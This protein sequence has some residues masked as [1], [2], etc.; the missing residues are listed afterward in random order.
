MEQ[1]VEFILEYGV[2]IGSVVISA[3]FLLVFALITFTSNRR[4]HE[5]ESESHTSITTPRIFALNVQNDH[6]IFFNRGSYNKRREGTMELFYRQF[7]V[8]EVSRIQK[9]INEL[10]TNDN[11]EQHFNVDVFVRTMRRTVSSLLLVKSIE[12]DKQTIHLESF[13]FHHLSPRHQ[14]NQRYAKKQRVGEAGQAR[15]EAIFNKQGTR[16]FGFFGAVSLAFAKS[17]K[18]YEFDA[19]PHIL[20]VLKDI[21]AMYKNKFQYVS[22]HGKNQ[23]AIYF[24]KEVN[25]FEVHK[26]MLAI[27][28]KIESFFE[29]NGITMYSVAHAVSEA[30]EFN[31]FKTFART[32]FELSDIAHRRVEKMIFY[33]P[34]DKAPDF[35]LTYFKNEISAIINEKAF[36][37]NFQPLVD[38]HTSEVFGQ[39]ASYT[40]KHPLFKT[41]KELKEYAVATK[42]EEELFNVTLVETLAIFYNNR[43]NERQHIFIP[44][45]LSENFN[46]QTCF[47]T[48][49]NSPK[50]N[51]VFMIEEED[52]AKLHRNSDE[53][54]AARLKAISKKVPLALIIHDTELTLPNELYAHFNYFIVDHKILDKT[55]KDER[56]RLYLLASLGKLTRYNR[57]VIFHEL[58]K[59]SEIEYY[60][61][62]G[63]DYVSSNEISKPEPRIVPLDKR[64]AMR[65]INF[66]KRKG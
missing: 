38:P 21:A 48:L 25:A 43:R 14:I 5:L 55:S 13:L 7:S 61:R 65:I 44:L 42:L 62:A 33:N 3:I 10:L 47:A 53:E 57:L 11:A 20:F 22:H 26:V 8:R 39:V 31:D 63:A 4:F 54:I 49:N 40:L 27:K 41:F 29:L 17:K 46:V 12:K 37:V 28:A 34:R 45:P 24:T 9:W 64:K 2:F 32:T 50:I 52:V 15:L 56:E 30:R 58:S 19:E 35:N 66:S 51:V 36:T 6:V 1:F 18:D 60:I 59:W 23:V 16:G